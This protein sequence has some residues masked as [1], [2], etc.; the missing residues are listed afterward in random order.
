MIRAIN[1]VLSDGAE[2]YVAKDIKD[3][4]KFMTLGTM[5]LTLGV[6]VQTQNVVDPLELQ[7]TR[8]LAQIPNIFVF[9]DDNKGEY[10]MLTTA[11]CYSGCACYTFSRTMAKS[12]PS[13]LA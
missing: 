7:L 13:L 9:F 12:N 3:I 4:T 10:I 2:L 6:I 8:V 11:M 1:S 5:T